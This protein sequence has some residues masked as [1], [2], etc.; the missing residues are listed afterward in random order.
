ML[1]TLNG[2]VIEKV[3]FSQKFAPET[4]KRSPVWRACAF[5]RS[6]FFLSFLNVFVC[7]ESHHCT[8]DTVHSLGSSTGWAAANGSGV[9]RWGLRHVARWQ[10]DTGCFLWPQISTNRVPKNP[11]VYNVWWFVY[12]HYVIIFPTQIAILVVYPSWHTESLETLVSA[13]PS[14]SSRLLNSKYC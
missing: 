6:I 13:L 3:M 2:Q 10:D 8:L 12:H 7:L 14:D 1:Q 9:G 11:R 4:S 5:K